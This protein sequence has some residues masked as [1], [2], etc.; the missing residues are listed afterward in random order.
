LVD[1]AVTPRF[2]TKCCEYT[3][4]DALCAATTADLAQQ[5]WGWRQ[6]MSSGMLPVDQMRRITVSPFVR[7]IMLRWIGGHSQSIEICVFKYRS[8]PSVVLK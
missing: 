5:I 2:E 4:D 3:N 7:Y 1:S 6:L 8:M